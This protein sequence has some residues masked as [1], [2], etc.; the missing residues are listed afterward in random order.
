MEAS[1]DD[2]TVTLLG[3]TDLP[4]TYVRTPT[5]K[6][7]VFNCRDTTKGKIFVELRSRCAKTIHKT[8]S[9]NPRLEIGGSPWN[10][11]WIFES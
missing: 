8:D 10:E 1:N 11:A 2:F 5:A 7:L 3:T 6:G 9:Y 4:G